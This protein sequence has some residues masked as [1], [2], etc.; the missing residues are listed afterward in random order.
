MRLAAVLVLAA[1]AASAQTPSPFLTAPGG[2]VEEQ[3]AALPPGEGREVVEG[4]CS[5]CHSIR[6]VTQ[7]RLPRERWD[8]LL[9]WM[10]AEQGMPEPDAETRELVLDYLGSHLSPGEN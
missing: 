9:D 1:G 10:V 5:G 6:L 3:E 8:D 7:Q 2:G 4:L